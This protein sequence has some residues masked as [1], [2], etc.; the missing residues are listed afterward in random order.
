MIGGQIYGCEQFEFE[1]KRNF[2]IYHGTSGP[3]KA[4]IKHNHKQVKF[5]CW[6]LADQLLA[7]SV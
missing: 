1:Y 4:K 2:R 7:Q 5:N 6:Y 3:A